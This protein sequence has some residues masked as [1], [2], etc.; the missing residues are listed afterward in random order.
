[1][2]G[3]KQD[4]QSFQMGMHTE[5]LGGRTQ[6]VYFTP[7][8]EENFLYPQA[9]DVDFNKRTEFDAAREDFEGLIRVGVHAKRRIGDVIGNTMVK[10][11]NSGECISGLQDG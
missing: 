7:E 11:E 8:E 6:Q 9:L 4:Q 2:A 1:M 5:Q 10:L 3:M